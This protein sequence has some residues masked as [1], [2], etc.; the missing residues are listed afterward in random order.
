MHRYDLYTRKLKIQGNTIGR[1]F[2]K[3]PWHS[4]NSISPL[5]KDLHLLRFHLLN[6]HAL[7]A[8]ADEGTKIRR[9]IG[10]FPDSPRVR[11]NN[12]QRGFKWGLISFGAG[13]GERR[14]CASA[15]A[16]GKGAGTRPG[17]GGK[18]KC[19]YTP[20]KRH[21]GLVH[22][23]GGTSRA[24]EERQETVEREKSGGRRERDG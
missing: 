9:K 12:N 21:A 18:G 17:D 4:R 13:G 8:I 6:E 24:A 7:P 11:D 1:Y 16:E 2:R 22:G 19:V 23:I 3:D 14:R 10:H 15:I 5:H 20:A